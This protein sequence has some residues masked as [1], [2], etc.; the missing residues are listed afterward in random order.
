MIKS[1]KHKG[2]RIFYESGSKEG[3]LPAHARR[4]KIILQLL[5]AAATPHCLE[6]PGMHFHS[7][8]GNLTDFYS[9][10]DSGNWRVIFKFEAGHAHL[11]NYVDYH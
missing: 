9:V 7:L 3:I 5:D 4:L 2:L 11:V 8:K 6:L 1:W 10:R